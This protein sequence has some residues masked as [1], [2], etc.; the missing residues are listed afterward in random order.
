[1]PSTSLTSTGTAVPSV[2]IDVPEPPSA[3]L[4]LALV[5]MADDVLTVSTHQR[6]NPDGASRCHAHPSFA[7]VVTATRSRHT[8]PAAKTTNGKT[9]AHP[10]QPAATTTNT[11]HGS[12][13]EC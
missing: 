3:T 6:Y 7:P 2:R 8:A 12:V 4:K 11:A 10:Q 5:S 13:P 9:I 1:V